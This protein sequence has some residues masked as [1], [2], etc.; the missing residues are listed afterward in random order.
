MYGANP[1]ARVHFGSSERKSVSARWPPT[2]RQPAN[3]TFESARIGCYMPKNS[4]IAMYYY[5]TIS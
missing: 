3:L 5:S 2:R 1:Y 4:P